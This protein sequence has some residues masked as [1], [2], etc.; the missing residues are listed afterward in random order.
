[1]LM[2]DR[3]T[4]I[5]ATGGVHGKG[6]LDAELDIKQTYGFQ[7]HFLND[8]VMPGCLG[9]DALWQLVAFMWDGAA[10]PVGDAPLVLVS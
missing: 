1:M 10:R 3:I 7:C 5:N 6:E 4:N 9:L 2:F 8:P